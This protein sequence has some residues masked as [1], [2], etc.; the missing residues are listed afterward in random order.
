MDTE[1]TP[2]NLTETPKSLNLTIPEHKAETFNPRQTADHVINLYREFRTKEISEQALG[3]QDV[4]ELKEQTEQ[5]E[6]YLSGIQE[7][8]NN[9]PQMCLI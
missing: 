2:V 8:L 4:S 6:K 3:K 1:D 9:I 7:K 5:L